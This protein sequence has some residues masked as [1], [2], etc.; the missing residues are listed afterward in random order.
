M[1]SYDNGNGVQGKLRIERRDWI[2][3]VAA[4]VGIIATLLGGFGWV[5]VRVFQTKETALLEHAA[6]R[7]EAALEKQ[8]A[9]MQKSFDKQLDGQRDSKIGNNTKILTT[10]HANQ[11]TIMHELDISRRRIK[12]LPAGLSIDM[13]E[14]TP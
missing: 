8:R 5:A 3:L 10:I 13:D 2:T 7:Q 4:V 12:P 14:G 9:E 6:I 1:A 11:Q